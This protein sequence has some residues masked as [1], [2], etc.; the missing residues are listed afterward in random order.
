MWDVSKPDVWFFF[1]CR[2]LEGHG[3][4]AGWFFSYLLASINFFA[5]NKISLKLF[6][7]A[8]VCWLLTFMYHIY[9]IVVHWSWNLSSGMIK[10]F[11]WAVSKPDIWICF[12]CR[13]LEGCGEGDGF[14]NFKCFHKYIDWIQGSSSIYS[15]LKLFR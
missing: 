4:G 10:T 8:S 5:W 1:P 6:F 11:Q 3:E 15:S 7:Q 9:W 12:P 2:F 14:L 13:F